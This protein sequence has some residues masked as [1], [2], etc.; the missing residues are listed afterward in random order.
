MYYTP[1]EL[2]PEVPDQEQWNLDGDYVHTVISYSGPQ[3][4]TMQFFFPKRL[5]VNIAGGFLGVDESSLT[6]EQFVD[7]MSEATNMII[8]SFLGRIDPGGACKIGIPKAEMVSDF[9]PA[10]S[11]A[12]DAVAF[13]SDFGYLWMSCVV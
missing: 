10:A 12:G 2:L 8:G 1:I 9:S 3:T 6:E 11:C 5:A 4:A 13:M 7:T